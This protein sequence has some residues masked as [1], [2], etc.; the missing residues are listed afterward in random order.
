MGEPETSEP[1]A[2]EELQFDHA[3]YAEAGT[4]VTI[5]ASCRQ[6]IPDAYYEVGSHILCPP[7]RV[8]IEASLTG[9][10]GAARFLRATVF[11]AAGAAA[12]AALFFGV[13]QLTGRPFFI[14]ALVIGFLVGTA[15]RNGA[16]GRGGWVYQ[17]LAIFLTYSAI[18]VSCYVA[19][20]SLAA[21]ERPAA[22]NAA[23]APGQ[24]GNLP[25]PPGRTVAFMALMAVV[26]MRSSMMID[27]TM[28]RSMARR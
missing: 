4:P 2:S 24:P 9:G 10:S 25:L 1:A 20:A 12:G 6:P 7:C 27:V 26:S 28:L 18:A 21:R 3:E 17:L 23:A 13:F 8:R 5:C 15:V 19:L 11:G 14:V 16:R 22:V